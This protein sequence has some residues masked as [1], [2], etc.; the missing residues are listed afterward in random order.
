M[1]NSA[2]SPNLSGDQQIKIYRQLGA[3]H[4][5]LKKQS[6]GNFDKEKAYLHEA[7]TPIKLV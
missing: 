1:G 6:N 5:R 4:E 7:L 2:S 3:E